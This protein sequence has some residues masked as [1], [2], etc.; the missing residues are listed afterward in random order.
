[1]TMQTMVVTAPCG[2]GV[3]FHVID[4]VGLSSDRS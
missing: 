3:K 2:A 1:M 4:G